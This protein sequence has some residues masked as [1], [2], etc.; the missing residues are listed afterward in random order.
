M[1][2]EA[3]ARLVLRVAVGCAIA[4][5]LGGLWGWHARGSVV[6]GFTS[7]LYVAATVALLL[8]VMGVSSPSRRDSMAAGWVE[9]MARRRTFEE[10]AANRSDARVSDS[11]VF[12]LVA[13]VL[14][15]LGVLSETL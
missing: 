11:V 1:I 14:A 8:G 13:V 7:G 5:A 6:A 10:N 15:G 3:L 2:L 12:I 4:I 9:K